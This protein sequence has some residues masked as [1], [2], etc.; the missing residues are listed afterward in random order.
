MTEDELRAIE[1]RNR[2]GPAVCSDHQSG[3][4]CYYCDMAALLAETRRL[5][6]VEDAL[7][8]LLSACRNERRNPDGTF[9]DR[10]LEAMD[11]GYEAL[12]APASPH[13]APEATERG[14]EGR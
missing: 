1:Y 7:G 2:L 5:R 14:K 13:V 9:S 6:A 11:A 4:A 3:C 12:D 10:L 8:A